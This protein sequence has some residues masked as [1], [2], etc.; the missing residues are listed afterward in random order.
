MSSIR[1]KSG[2][3]LPEHFSNPLHQQLYTKLVTHLTSQYPQY[4]HE[5]TED[6]LC[7]ISYNLQY[8]M[9]VL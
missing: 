3:P 2:Y 5:I 7:W 8:L 6:I 4:N 9:E 1:K